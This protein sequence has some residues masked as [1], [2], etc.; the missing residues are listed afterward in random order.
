ME[1]FE[2]FCQT[3]PNQNFQLLS[4]NGLSRVYRLSGEYSGVVKVSETNELISFIENERAILSRLN[5]ASLVR[6]R[7]D[8][9]SREGWLSLEDVGTSGNLQQ[10]L[11][12]L[13]TQGRSLPEINFFLAAR[14]YELAA[15]L[16]YLHAQNIV[17]LDIK[18]ENILLN[19]NGRAVLIDFSGSCSLPASQKVQIHF[20]PFFAHP[21]LTS[22]L[23]S[24]VLERNIAEVESKSIHTR[25]DLYSLGRT[26]LYFLKM[27]D[28]AFP[29][30]CDYDYH[31]N[32]LHLLGCRLLQ[33]KNL[34]Q[35]DYLQLRSDFQKRGQEFPIVTETW[36]QLEAGE[37][38]ELQIQSAVE[39]LENLEKLLYPENY[40]RKLP[41]IDP[42]SFSTLSVAEGSP[43]AFTGRLKQ[44]LQHP[45]FT[46]LKLVPQLELIETIYPTANH[47]RFEHSLGVYRNATLYV[48]HLFL[49]PHN[50]F[51]RQIVNTA[52]LK[53]VLL[54]ALL[55]D[56]GQHPFGHTLE[57]ARPELHHE[58]L[59]LAFLKNKSQDN[60]G[61]TLAD[62]IAGKDYWGVDL[63]QVI[64]LLDIEQKASDTPDIFGRLRLKEM[65]LASII[66]GPIDV[67]KLDYLLRDSRRCQLPYGLAIDPDRLI[68]SLTVIMI[69]TETGRLKVNIGTYEKGRNA[70]ESMS[71]AR[72]M[73]YQTVYW[74][75]SSRAMRSMIR[76]VV[77]VVSVKGKG[78][79]AAFS[80]ELEKF[81]GAHDKPAE[82]T[83][84]LMLKFLAE[85][86]DLTGKEL[87]EMI[88]ARNYYKRLIVFHSSAG[89]LTDA[90]YEK[91]QKLNNLTDFQNQLQ[92]KIKEKYA[93]KLNSSS[94]PNVSLLAPQVSS[95]VLAELVKPRRILVD[96]PRPS[97]GS[98][99][100]LFFIPEPKMMQRNLTTR[101][102]DGRRVSDVWESIHAQLMSFAARASVF[103]HPEIRNSLL[104]ALGPEGIT[105]SVKETL[106]R[107]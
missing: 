85:R 100:K 90:E 99:D 58:S 79:S 74:H 40:L 32:Y 65:M 47:N 101:S 66:D 30:I 91:I 7:R 55:H 45:V 84:D 26:I 50:P 73:M 102:D 63:N 80:A 94:L 41:E 44:I 70:A 21:D 13:I 19:E 87:L 81:L 62:L 93:L 39:L 64:N 35:A 18:P 54:S 75:H 42:D 25:F 16:V 60:Q 61:R 38:A 92:L 69:R 48:R 3:L 96:A 67:D 98:R 83:I 36:L 15:G 27:I 17:H 24:S 2:E 89:L 77:R 82:V 72:Y 97:T 5:N 51:F 52:D 46:R 6:V 56:L 88:K 53:A 86:T 78:K 59:T 76:E 20:T 107:Y 106:R 57:E 12:N 71:F 23:N 34:S 4:S 49:D 33:G 11:G 10:A 68:R 103:C 31:F 14:M 43:V 9:F 8:V 95:R 104:A 1:S 29:D 28:L 22:E 37:I 105:E